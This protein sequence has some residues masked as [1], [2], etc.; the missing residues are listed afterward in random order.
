MK[1]IFLRWHWCRWNRWWSCGIFIIMW[2]STYITREPL[3][4]GTPYTPGIISITKPTL[5]RRATSA[6]NTNKINHLASQSQTC[7]LLKNQ[8]A[9][10]PS[11][12]PLRCNICIAVR[13]FLRRME[14]ISFWFFYIER[15]L[16]KVVQSQVKLISDQLQIWSSHSSSTNYLLFYH[17]IIEMSTYFRSMSLKTR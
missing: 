12:T 4:N 5:E 9:W 15:E 3:D 13:R 1:N 14:R 8:N 2:S 11:L 17:L 6:V 10:W 7:Q 16:W